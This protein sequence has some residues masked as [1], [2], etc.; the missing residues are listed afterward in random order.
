MTTEAVVRR[1]ARA[2]ALIIG[3]PAIMLPSIT[4]SAGITAPIWTALKGVALGLKRL[5]AARPASAV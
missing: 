3:V 5:S 2:L 4:L 1:A